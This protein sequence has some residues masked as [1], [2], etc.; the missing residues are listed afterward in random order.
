[1]LWRGSGQSPSSSLLAQ[2]LD[3]EGQMDNPCTSWLADAYW[4]NITELDKLTNFHGLMNS[5]EQYPR[6]WHLW[7]TSATPEKAMLPGEWENACN[8]MQR[9]LIVRSLRQD[10]VAF[11]VASFIV[12]NLG[13]R[14]VEPP[15]LNMKLVLEDS[16]PRTPLVFILS[17]GVDPSGALLQL[18]EQMGMAQRFHALS[19][20][21]GQAPIAARLLREG[22]LQ[23]HWVFLANCHL[24]LSWMPNLDKLVEQLQVEEPHPSFRLWLS[25][26]PHPDFPIS[27]LQASIKMTT[28]PPKARSLT[29]S[30]AHSPFPPFTT[31]WRNCPL[32]DPAQSSSLAPGSKRTP[33]SEFHLATRRFLLARQNH[34]SRTLGA[35]GQP[36]TADDLLGPVLLAAPP[37]FE[38]PLFA[39]QERCMPWWQRALCWLSALRGAQVCQ[40][41]GRCYFWPRKKV[42]A[43]WNLGAAWEEGRWSAGR[44]GSPRLHPGEICPHHPGSAEPPGGSQSFREGR[45][46]TAYLFATG[47]LSVAKRALFL[48]V[49]LGNHWKLTQE[50]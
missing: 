38:E 45:T 43:T 39:F 29:S 7:Y 12:S 13:S 19:L 37:F 27:I 15:V 11:C 4:D 21:Q 16:T 10:R 50:L 20:G 48:N 24:S 14:F 25:S 5:F 47:F 17:P 42:E 36:A 49:L 9:M 23:G 3:R 31:R 34:K 1:M 46:F 40:S 41:G 8:E 26:S 22:V 35:S 2:V 18:A 44:G 33:G 28:E 32:P 6:D 30:L